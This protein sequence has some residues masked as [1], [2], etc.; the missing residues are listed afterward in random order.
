[1]LDQANVGRRTRAYEAPDVIAAFDDLER[2]LA[3]PTGATL[4]PSSFPPPPL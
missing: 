4:A 1:V 2:Q 3:S